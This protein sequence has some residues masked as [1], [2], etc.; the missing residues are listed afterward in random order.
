MSASSNS[1]PAVCP[2]CDARSRDVFSVGE[3]DIMGC[4]DCKHRFVAGRL[5]QQHVGEMFGDA[6]FTE[7]GAGY[8]DYLRLADIKTEHGRRYVDLLARH[9]PTG[10]V[11]D[12]GAAAGFVLK[13]FVDRGWDGVGLEPNIHMAEYGRKQL[14]LDMRSSTLEEF[15]CNEQFDLVNLIQVVGHFYDLRAAMESAAALTK[16]GGSWLVE[17]WDASSLVAKAM[18]SRWHNYVPPSVIHWFGRS[19]MDRLMAG[20]GFSRVAT[21][22][23]KKYVDGSYLKSFL[24]YT[25]RAW[26]SSPALAKGLDLIP[27]DMRV[28]YP[29]FDL[30]WALFRELLADG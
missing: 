5:D 22:A 16:P 1:I 26:P 13:A 18:G 7:G 11:L 29:A 17:Y 27:D 24:K 30:K 2:V 8:P 4:T 6:Y 12:V 25:I 19:D 21:G 23:P 20:F 10:R 3:Y 28:R 9:V 14:G 15:Q